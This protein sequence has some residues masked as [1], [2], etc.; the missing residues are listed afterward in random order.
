MRT[1]KIG[2]TEVTLNER[3]YKQLLKRFDTSKVVIK[4]DYHSINAACICKFYPYPNARN[5]YGDCSKCPLGSEYGFMHCVGYMR[6]IADAD[7][8]TALLGSTNIEWRRS[9][10]SDAR[11]QLNTIHDFLLRIPRT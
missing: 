6:D 11:A 8:I 10:D 3:D 4:R 2:D 5:M 9:R 7:S 1:A